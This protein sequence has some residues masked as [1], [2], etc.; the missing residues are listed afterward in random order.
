FT[1]YQLDGAFLLWLISFVLTILGFFILYW[2]IPN[3]TV[4]VYAAGIAA[5]LSA[6]LFEILKNFFSFV[7]SNF[8][9]YE[10]I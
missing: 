10:I 9:S 5:C 8:T 2:T 3:R 1:G 4:P 7:M 6:V